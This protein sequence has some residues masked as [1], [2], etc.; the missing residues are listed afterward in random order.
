[1]PDPELAEDEWEKYGSR[2]VCFGDDWI[3]VIVVK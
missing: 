1:M 3:K 2:V